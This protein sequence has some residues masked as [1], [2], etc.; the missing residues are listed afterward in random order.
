MFVF[1]G[2]KLGCEKRLMFWETRRLEVGAPG[3]REGPPA[4]ER[5]RTQGQETPA[6]GSIILAVQRRRGSQCLPLISI[7]SPRRS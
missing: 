2:T 6:I 3:K 1:G 5:P 4:G 7:P